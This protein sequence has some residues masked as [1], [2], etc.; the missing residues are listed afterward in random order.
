MAWITT[1]E[2]GEARGL[3]KKLYDEAIARAGKVWSIVRLM[4]LRP[5]QVRAS[6]GLYAE[7]MFGESELTRAERE[8]V[9][10]VV[11]RANRCHY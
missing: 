8:M 11:S 9:A 5:R 2:V 10:V 3:L 6:M 7:V 1:V 4:S